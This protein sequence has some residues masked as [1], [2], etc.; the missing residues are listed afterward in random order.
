VEEEK[1]NM[2]PP[3]QQKVA[4]VSTIMM[5]DTSSKPT[6]GSS[7]PKHRKPTMPVVEFNAGIERLNKQDEKL[8]KLKEKVAKCLKALEEVKPQNYMKLSKFVTE[9]KRVRLSLLTLSRW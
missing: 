4:D 5:I 9:V 2:R 7:A 8:H 3:P 6:K 1:E